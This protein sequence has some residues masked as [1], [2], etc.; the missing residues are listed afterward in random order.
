MTEPVPNPN[1]QL[2]DDETGQFFADLLA[3]D[4]PGFEDQPTPDASKSR[5]GLRDAFK[6]KEDDKPR[7]PAAR[8]APYKKDEFIEPVTQMYVVMALGVSPFDSRCASVLAE[9]AENCARAWDELAKAN[10][11]VRKTLRTLTQGTAWGAVIM[12]HAPI[13]IAVASHH[14]PGMSVPTIRDDISD[15]PAAE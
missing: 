11:Q 5:R 14:M 2:A 15:I 9:N 12:A 6:S 1:G 7:K 10:P 3:H 8:I 13:L 4:A